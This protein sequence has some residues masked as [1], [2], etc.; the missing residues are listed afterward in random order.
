[1]QPSVERTTRGQHSQ[2]HNSKAKAYAPSNQQQAYRMSPYIAIC[3]YSRAVFPVTCQQHT[4]HTI[5]RVTD[6]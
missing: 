1:M 6:T 3:L 5:E 2:T 4:M